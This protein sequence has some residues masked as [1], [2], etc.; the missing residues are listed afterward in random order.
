[1][2]VFVFSLKDEFLGIDS[3]SSSGE[4]VKRTLSLDMS[5]A[6]MSYIRQVIMFTALL[7]V[8]GVSWVV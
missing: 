4:K 8:G 6:G 7:E 1:M 2:F 5:G 3:D